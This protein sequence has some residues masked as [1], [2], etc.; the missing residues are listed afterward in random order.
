M[1]AGASVGSEMRPR[2][3]G[4][5]CRGLSYPPRPIPL[6]KQPPKSLRQTWQ[7]WVKFILFY[8]PVRDTNNL[9]YAFV[10]WLLLQSAI[11]FAVIASNIHWQW[12]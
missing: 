4:L 8:V 1:S 12:T 9:R 5:I 10:M 2:L 6:G 11:M 7:N 3:G